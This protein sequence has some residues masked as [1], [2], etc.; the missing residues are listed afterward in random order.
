M[1]KRYRGKPMEFHHL[2]AELAGLIDEDVPIGQGAGKFQIDHANENPADNRKQNLR[3]IRH[4]I[5]RMRAGT[6]TSGIKKTTTGNQFQFRKPMI[7]YFQRNFDQDVIDEVKE[8]VEWV[9]EFEYFNEKKHWDH[10]QYSRAAAERRKSRLG[11]LVIEFLR[12]RDDVLE[13]FNIDEDGDV[14]HYNM[15]DELNAQF[16]LSEPAIIE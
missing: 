7:K 8:D 6:A 10:T 11:L 5:N 1:L 14:C 2:V 4:E 16:T 13:G 9:R 12:L 15:E 3:A